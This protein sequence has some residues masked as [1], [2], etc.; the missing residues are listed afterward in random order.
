MSAH[1]V[2]EIA[3]LATDPTG[4]EVSGPTPTFGPIA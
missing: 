2:Y 1:V 3:H 4:H